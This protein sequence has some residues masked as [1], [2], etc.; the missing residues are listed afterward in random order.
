MSRYS[1]GLGNVIATSSSRNFGS[2]SAM[3]SGLLITA[4]GISYACL[5]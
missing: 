3:R 5:S 2:F 1:R 4:I